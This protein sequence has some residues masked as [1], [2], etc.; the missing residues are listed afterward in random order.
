MG[1]QRHS[2]RHMGAHLWPRAGRLPV[3]MAGWLI[4]KAKAH[5]DSL[6]GC[7]VAHAEGQHPQAAVQAQLQQW[8]YSNSPSSQSSIAALK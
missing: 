4:C 5:P 8:I 1:Q 6:G 3:Q 2:A 7:P